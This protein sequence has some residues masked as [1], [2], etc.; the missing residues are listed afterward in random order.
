MKR[1][2]DFPFFHYTRKSEKSQMYFT[3]MKRKDWFQS[4][5]IGFAFYLYKRAFFADTLIIQMRMAT[6]DFP[7]FHLDIQM[8]FG[9]LHRLYNSK[10]GI[11]FTATRS[12]MGGDC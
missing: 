8:G 11:P 7:K 4:S 2:H 3:F 6:L 1:K 10:I 5:A 9:K 12:A